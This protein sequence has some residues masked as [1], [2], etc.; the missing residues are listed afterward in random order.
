MFKSSYT[1]HYRRG[2]IKLLE[3]LEFRSYNTATSR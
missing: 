2:L 3:V 1:N